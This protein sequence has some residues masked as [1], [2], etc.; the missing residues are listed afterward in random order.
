MSDRPDDICPRPDEVPQ[1]GT[2]P[3]A[4]PIFPATVYA[5]ESPEQASA[6]LAGETAGY[7]YSRN[8]HP[9]ADRLAARCAELHGADRAV[10]TGSGMAALGLALLTQVS[11]GDHVLTSN[12][13]YGE[14]LALFGE[15]A[16]RLGIESTTVDTCDLEAVERAF[17]PRT[18]LLVVE[19]IA[20]P[21][22]R[23][24][25]LARLA[26]RAHTHGARLLVDNTFASPVICR[27][28][29]HGADLVVE[30]ITKII[31]GHSDVM[32]GLLAGG[33]ATWDRVPTVH[34]RWGFCAAP[35]DC[36]LAA[37][38]LGTLALRVER[39]ADNARRLA[40]MLTT[41]RGIESIHYPGLPS[42]PDH[43]IAERQF[44]GGFGNM[45]SFTIPGGTDAARKFIAAAERI[46][47]CP[48][49]GELCTTL[50]HPESTSHRRL[51]AEGRAALG[52]HGGTIR[53]SMGIESSE[54]VLGAVQQ[55]L[56]G[57]A[58]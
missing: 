33:T 10:I 8:G 32:L 16:A 22:L 53:L 52:I 40:E 1:M 36:W 20:N 54:H 48:S 12:Q 41:H 38:G 4:A 55:G 30:S 11:R 44:R 49:L 50:T 58:E 27:P 35:I 24:A 21:M 39:A 5:C 3:L 56:A 19:T 34:S 13:L 51:S 47:F 15:E 45:L 23:V 25:D 28:L 9:G 2:R 42:H 29:E 18:R 17:T 37:R 6:L 14:S 46:P 26:D 57:V 31:N 7:I 43:A